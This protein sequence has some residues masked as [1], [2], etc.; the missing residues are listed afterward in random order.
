MCF[1]ARIMILHANWLGQG[2]LARQIAVEVEAPGFSPKKCLFKETALA[3][4]NRGLSP[5]SS[6]LSARLKPCPST[7]KISN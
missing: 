5:F 6:A 3:G 7:D 2:W 4:A 1:M